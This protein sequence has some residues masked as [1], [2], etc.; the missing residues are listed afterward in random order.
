MV[1]MGSEWIVAERSDEGFVLSTNN[2]A[3]LNTLLCVLCKLRGGCVQETKERE[4]ER[5]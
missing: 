5:S 3:M 2:K 4:R 1:H